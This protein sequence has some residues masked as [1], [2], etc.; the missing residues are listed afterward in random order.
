MKYFLTLLFL[1]ASILIQ[2]QCLNFYKENCELPTDWDYEFDSQSLSVHLFAGQSF[3]FKAVFYEGKDYFIGFCREEGLP[4]IKFKF[5]SE[6]IVI[7]NSFAENQ[8]DYLEFIEFST[9]TTRIAMI[10]VKVEKES[11]VNIDVNNKKCLGIIVGSKD[12]K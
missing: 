10:E 4:K 3:K 6:D 12:T 1:S 7:D 11:G 8:N 5:L 9:T 2:S